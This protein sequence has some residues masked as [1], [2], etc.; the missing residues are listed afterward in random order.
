MKA[1][2]VM[3]GNVI[4]ARADTTIQEIAQLLMERGIGGL[5]VLDSAGA[6]VGMV[7][8]GD[9]LALI[10]PAEDGGGARRSW[11][12]SLL[13]ADPSSGARGFSALRPPRPATAGEIMSAPV[14]TVSEDTDAAEIARLFQACRIKRAPVVSQAKTVGIVSRGDLLRCVGEQPAAPASRARSGLLPAGLAERFTHARQPPPAR[15]AEPAASDSPERPVTAA[16]FRGLMNDHA[17]MEVRRRDEVRRQGV[18]QHYRTVVQLTEQ[19]LA[20]E[21]WGKLV[22]DARVAAQNGEREFLLLRFP[23][24]L[25]SDHGRAINAPEPGWP[26]TLRG[27][28]AEIYLRWERELKPQGFHIAARVLSFPGGVPGDIGL[29]LIWRL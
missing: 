22:T 6:P 21:M 13:A 19:H 26:A 10:D 28:A 12:L 7:S 23:C 8:K 9:L 18:E 2:D 17:R 27:E 1:R 5:P 11:W 15:V 4:A 29:F 14:V 20:D 25:C 3:S 16:D 24:D